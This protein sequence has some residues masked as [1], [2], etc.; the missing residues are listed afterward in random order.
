M[1]AAAGGGPVRP[2]RTPPAGDPRE[3]ALKQIP[4]RLE[5]V[6]V[7]PSQL[8]PATLPEVAIIGRS[9]VG[10]SSL[11]NVVLG[12][13]GLMRVSNTPGRTQA[14]LFVA[15]GEKGYVVDLPGYGFAKVPMPLKA[16]WGKLVETYLA[17]GARGAA[18]LLLDIRREPGDGDRVMADYFRRYGRPFFVVMTKADKVSRGTWNQ[19]AQAMTRALSLEPEQMP[20]PFSAVSGEG[21]RNVYRK[22]EE[23]ME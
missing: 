2:G 10:K 8:P 11:I 19:R 14:V 6:C 15:L 5:R 1:A 9:N 4:A 13:R 20:I 12:Q 23:S 3:V 22:I 18:C 7:T 21:V 16:A 17:R